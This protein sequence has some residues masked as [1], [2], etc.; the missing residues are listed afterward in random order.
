MKVSQEGMLINESDW[1]VFIGHAKATLDKLNVPQQEHE[2]VV[3]FILSTKSD[4][5]EV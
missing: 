4:I 5:V 2:E 1:S 3:A